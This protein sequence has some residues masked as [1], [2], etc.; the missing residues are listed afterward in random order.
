MYSYMYQERILILH[1]VE[2]VL[3]YLGMLFLPLLGVSLHLSDPFSLKLKTF[4]ESL[5]EY[6]FLS[7]SLSLQL[8][9]QLKFVVLVVS[10]SPGCCLPL[11]TNAGFHC[12]LLSL[13]LKLT[14]LV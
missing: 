9:L 13:L 3:V 5:L 8:S 2:L 12:H 4:F 11:G 14:L 1:G 6:L 7:C 10:L